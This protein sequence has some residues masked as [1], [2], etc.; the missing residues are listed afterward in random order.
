VKNINVTLVFLTLLGSISANSTFVLSAR[1]VQAP[2]R[3]DGVIEEVWQW[4]PVA[5]GFRQYEPNRGQLSETKSQAMVLYDSD[6]I[7]IAFSLWDSQPPTAQLTQRDADLFDDDAVIL[8][9]DTYHDRRSAYYFM[10][11][12]LSTQTDGRISNDGRTVDV[13]WD[14]PWQCASQQTEFGWTVEMSIPFTSLKYSADDSVKWGINFGRSSRRNLETSFW[15]GPLDSRFR[16]SQAGTLIGLNIKPPLHRQ[17][18]IPYGLTRFQ[19]NQSNQLDVGIDIRYALTTQTSAYVTI[20]PDFATIEADQEQVNLTRFELSL[21]EKRQF[22]LEGN[23]LF[24]QRIRTFY[25]RRIPNITIGGK[26]LGKQGPWSLAALATQ[27]KPSPDST[28]ATYTVAHAQKDIL[29]SSIIAF[30]IANRTQQGYNQGSA[31]IDA[32]LFF[33]GTLGMTAQLV[34]SYG[35]FEDGT[36]AYFFRPA[37]DSPTAHFHVRYTHLGEHVAENV[38]TIGFIR[39]DNRRELDSAFEKIFW[40]RSGLLERT[41]YDSNYN[42]YW[43]QDDTLRSW[44]ID[45]SIEVEFRNR[46]AFEIDYTEEFKRFEKDFRNRELGVALGYN[47]RE[48]QSVQVGLEFGK[49][50]DLDFWLWTAEAGYKVTKQL[51]LEYELQRLILNPDEESE[52]TWIHVLKADQFFTKDLY[53]RLFFQTNSAIDRKNLQAIFVYRYQ[54]PF[55]T[56]QLAYQRGTA[57]FGQRSQQG[58]TLFL[59][60]TRVF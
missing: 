14:A 15:A 12:L 24:K 23:E 54:P 13:T 56:I 5:D 26:L 37:Y 9:L 60:V 34:R 42:I 21:P 45:Q 49:N 29:G 19:E 25:S 58:N 4:A 40:F 51:S 17:Q 2:P 1:R 8:V 31:S 44:Q 38:N 7:Y 6:H 53:L 35:H 59:K 27:S 22:F 48:F 33:T 43:G 52:S 50:F 16:V 32:T 10:T 41:Q 3:I 46:L 11:N 18:V 36:W 20:N 30:M 39:D 57:E 55:G 47:T 28:K